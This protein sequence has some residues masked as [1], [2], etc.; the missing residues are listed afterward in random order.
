MTHLKHHLNF[1]TVGTSISTFSLPLASVRVTVFSVSV[2]PNMY[3][4]YGIDHIVSKLF[5]EILHSLLGYKL[6]KEDTFTFPLG[7]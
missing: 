5:V 1:I 7:V 4:K 3:L 6:L 2:E